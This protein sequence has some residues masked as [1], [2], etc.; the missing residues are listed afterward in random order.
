MER[1]ALYRELSLFFIVLAALYMLSLSSS[2][3]S[4]DGVSQKQHNGS[5]ASATVGVNKLLTAIL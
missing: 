4:F 2:M 3:A 1:K 5:N